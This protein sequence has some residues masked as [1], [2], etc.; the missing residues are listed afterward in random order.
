MPLYSFKCD[1]CATAFDKFMKMNS[2]TSRALCR[3]GK[4]AHKIFTPPTCITDTS[5]CMTGEEDRRFSE[6]GQRGV[7]IEG[8]KHWKQLLKQKGYCEQTQ[9]DLKEQD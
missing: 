1:K 9:T 3:C 5:F 6:A 7:K 2:N 4:W 8:R